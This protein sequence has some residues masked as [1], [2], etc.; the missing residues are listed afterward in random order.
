MSKIIQNLVNKHIVKIL[1]IYRKSITNEK[2]E[3][4]NYLDDKI[5]WEIDF[6]IRLIKEREVESHE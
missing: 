6:L 3:F 1:I 2:L 4:K 5:F